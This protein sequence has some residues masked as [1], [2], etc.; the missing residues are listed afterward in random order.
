MVRHLVIFAMIGAISANA[1]LT[2][3]QS[4]VAGAKPELPLQ[5]KERLTKSKMGVISCASLCPDGKLFAIAVPSAATKDLKTTEVAIRV[6]DADSGEE[7]QKITIN[8]DYVGSLGWE[9]LGRRIVVAPTKEFQS[10]EVGS[11]KMTYSLDLAAS[12]SN[13]AHHPSRKELAVVNRLNESVE[14]RDAEKGDVLSTIKQPDARIAIFSPDG[15]AI[16]IACEDKAIRLRNAKTGELVTTFKG[17]Q[18]RIWALCFADSGKI[19]AGATNEK[20]VYIWNTKNGE[21][22]TLSFPIAIRK[23]ASSLDGKWLALGSE[24]SKGAKGFVLLRELASGAETILLEKQS[25][26]TGDL[27]FSHDGTVLFCR[28]ENTIHVWEI[29]AGKKI[30]APK[31][32]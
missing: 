19:L 28:V 12:I 32:K 26:P 4:A 20:S 15:K 3:K 11:G 14:I 23:V 16:A 21:L 22:K 29:S 9:P 17:H 18:S 10:W 7:K 30:D 2:G 6:F 8:T 1:W 27:E 5:I 31:N 13:G 25:S 24:S